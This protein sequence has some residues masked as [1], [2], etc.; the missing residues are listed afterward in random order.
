LL[1]LERMSKTG[2][3]SVIVAERNFISELVE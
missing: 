3:S 2:R 1:R